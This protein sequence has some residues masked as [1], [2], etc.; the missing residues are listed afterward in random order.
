MIEPEKTRLSLDAL[1]E[2]SCSIAWVSVLTGLRIGEVL[3][4][5]W[6][7]VDLVNGML[8]VRQTVYEG[9]FDEPKT[10]R[11]N[12]SVPLGAKGIAVLEVRRPGT[13]N[14]DA[15]I[16]PTQN[17]SPMSRRNLLNRQ[18]APTAKRLGFQGINWHWLRHANATLH[19][20]LGTPLGTLQALLGHPSAE[21]TREIYIH[22]VPADARNAVE[23]VEYL[24]I[25][26]N[27]RK[28]EI[29]ERL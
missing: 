19:D 18:L 15:L 8:R 11:S 17:G 22:S 25:G 9:R 13:P 28:M 14:P 3:A 4:L 12:R 6:R 10:R 23:K 1:P 5:R 20:S 29:P 2:P 26:L 27:F 24:L 21:T 16:F 7:D